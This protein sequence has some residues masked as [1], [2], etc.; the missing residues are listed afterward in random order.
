VLGNE[1]AGVG[2]FGRFNQV[3]DP[4]RRPAGRSSRISTPRVAKLGP[5]QYYP[6]TL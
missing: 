2:D 6:K 5:G 4:E 3:S 1:Q